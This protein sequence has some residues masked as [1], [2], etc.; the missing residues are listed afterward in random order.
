[1][2]ASVSDYSESPTGTLCTF[3]ERRHDDGTVIISCVGEL[4]LT[5]S[6]ELE[7]RIGLALE[8]SPQTV[9]ADLSRVD[10]L[11]SSAM[12]VLVVAAELCTPD[13]RFVVIAH[14]PMTRRPMELV[15]VTEML[16]VHATLENALKALAK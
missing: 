13:V 2:G 6:P 4:D 3:G 9:I 14:G 15:G 10:F 11:A 1:M 7:R 16:T 5:T 12:S 8:R